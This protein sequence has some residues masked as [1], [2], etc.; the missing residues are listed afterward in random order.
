MPLYVHLSFSGGLSLELIQT[1]MLC[2]QDVLE[3]YPDMVIE[4]LDTKAVTGGLG[5]IQAHETF[6]AAPERCQYGRAGK[7]EQQLLTSPYPPANVLP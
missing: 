3:K 5:L 7:T 4:V 1:L 6:E 2:K